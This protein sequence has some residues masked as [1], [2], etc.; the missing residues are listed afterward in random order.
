MDAIQTPA[1][2]RRWRDFV[3]R[4]GKRMHLW[5]AAT[6][7]ARLFSRPMR[8]MVVARISKRGKMAGNE[9]ELRYA[10][11][12]LFSRSRKLPVGGRSFCGFSV[13]GYFL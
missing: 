10:I 2:G 6:L 4:E 9:S 13:S 11:L 7:P 12:H 1:C 3:A 8:K 5:L